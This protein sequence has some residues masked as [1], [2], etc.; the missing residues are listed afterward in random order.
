MPK[1]S[2][3]LVLCTRKNQKKKTD[4]RWFKVTF[5]SPSWRS[6]NPLK[7]SLNHPKKV[8]LN[9]LVPFKRKVNQF[10]LLPSF[11]LF[12][13]RNFHNMKFAP[14]VIANGSGKEDTKETPWRIPQGFHQTLMSRR[15]KN[16]TKDERNEWFQVRSKWSLSM[17]CERF[18]HHFIISIK[19][20]SHTSI[21]QF[22]SSP[23]KLWCKSLW[24]SLVK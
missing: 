5:S 16:H 22:P 8:T 6:L 3:Q 18:Y 20:S 17:D 13:S 10:V 9:H 15:P 12:K 7:G 1:T 14:E 23:G 4:T 21:F 2:G 19:L 24:Q 11:C